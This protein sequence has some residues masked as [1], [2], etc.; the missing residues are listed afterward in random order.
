MLGD[1][2]EL[3]PSVAS[4]ASTVFFFFR[5]IAEFLAD[6][7]MWQSSLNIIQELEGLRTRTSSVILRWVDR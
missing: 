2:G 5:F 1:I 6:E 4:F 3:H 7:K